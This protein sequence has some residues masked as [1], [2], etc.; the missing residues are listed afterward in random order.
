MVGYHQLEDVTAEKVT[1]GWYHTGDVME[2]DANGWHF[3]VGRVD[4]MFTCGGENVYP[5]DVEQLLERHELVHQASVVPVADGLKGELPVAFVVL[6]PEAVPTEADLRQWMIDNG[7]AYQH[8]RAVW[9]I[10]ELPLAGTAKID[11][12]VLTNEA[13]QR[14]TPRAP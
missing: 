13:A 3:F 12:A 8:P 11:R 9:F 5:G 14:W 4:D 7:P 2:S 6:T 10:D 1:N